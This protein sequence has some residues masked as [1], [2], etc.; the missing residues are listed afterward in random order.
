MSGLVPGVRRLLQDGVYGCRPLSGSRAG[1][2][3]WDERAWAL[4]KGR[5]RG[6]RWWWAAIAEHQDGAG[7]LTD[8]LENAS[9]CFRKK[10]DAECNV[11][12]VVGGW[13]GGWLLASG[14]IED[15]IRVAIGPKRCVSG[16]HEQR[17]GAQER[18]AGTAAAA[19]VTGL[20]GLTPE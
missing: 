15:V 17:F 5:E 6:V 16:V 3:E 10:G 18:R 4:G 19:L 9:D 1:T 11:N 20:G 12:L 8:P 7:G 14:R 2:K 13:M